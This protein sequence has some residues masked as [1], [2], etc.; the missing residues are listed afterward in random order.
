VLTL[1]KMLIGSGAFTS[2]LRDK[3]RNARQTATVVASLGA[4]ALVAVAVG[5]TCLAA[6]A[7]FAMR[8]LMADYQ[9]AL[10][11]G[12]GFIAIAGMLVLLAML[13]LK[14]R[15]GAPLST[16]ADNGADIPAAI[17][18]GGSSGADPLVQLIGSAVQSPVIMTALALGIVAG[19]ATK[20]SGRN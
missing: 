17:P 12:G 1:F 8:P 4:V 16:A 14:R 3:I 9:A 11:V 13:R 20:R 6:S 2:A 19:R 18:A 5:A 7:F 10:L 15:G